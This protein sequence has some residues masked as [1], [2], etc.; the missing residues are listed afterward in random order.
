MGGEQAANVLAQVGVLEVLQ[1]MLR[2]A[3]EQHGTHDGVEG[4]TQ[5]ANVLAQGR[6]LLV[7]HLRQEATVCRKGINSIAPPPPLSCAPASPTQPHT[8]S[9]TSASKVELEKRARDGHSWPAEEEA[10]FRR[11]MQ[12]SADGCVNTGG[13][14]YAACGAS[15]SS[16]A[17]AA[18]A[19]PP[20]LPLP[21]AAA[22]ASP[23]PLLPRCC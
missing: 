8:L 21:A 1:P 2:Q 17:P 7:L 15:S 23:P 12:V 14:Y 16:F 10:A 5:A 19:L 9:H 4:G 11:D 20:P 13:S 3:L 6:W 22:P 18:A